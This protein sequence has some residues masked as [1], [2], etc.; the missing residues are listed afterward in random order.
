MKFS[1]IFNN[2]IYKKKEEVRENV[3]IMEVFNTLSKASKK[4]IIFNFT[5]CDILTKFNKYKHEILDLSSSIVIK[6]RKHKF[7]QH[8]MEVVLTSIEELVTAEDA[9]LFEQ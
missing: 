6:N 9:F 5:S 3:G 8:L 4:N 2:L 1:N 7:H